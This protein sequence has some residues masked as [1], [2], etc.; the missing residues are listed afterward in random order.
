MALLVLIGAV[1][2][3]AATRLLWSPSSGPAAAGA[4]AAPGTS[5]GGGNAGATGPADAAAIAATVND[6]IVD[7]TTSS[8]YDRSEAAGTGMVLTSDGEVLTNNHVIAGATTISVTDVGNGRTYDA[9]VVGYDRSHDVAVLQ[10]TDASGLATV[11]LGDSSAV[12][13]GQSVVGVGNAGGR[14]GTPSFA[15]GTVTAL[16]RSITASDPATGAG[17]ELDGL[18]ET[19][20]AIVAGDSGGPLVDTDGAVIGIDSAASAGLRSRVPGGPAYAVPIN[21]A[22]RIVHQIESGTPTADVHIGPTAF[23]GVGLRSSAGGAFVARVVPGGPAEA[24]GLEVGDTITAL[25]GHAVDD[26][27]SLTDLMLAEQPG[28]DV[29]VRYRDRSGADGTATVRLGSGPAQ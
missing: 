18:I 20:A 23:L 13:V 19:D 27:R 28:A 25:D 9:T 26:A 7:I 2:G 15:G 1:G 10:L 6:G 5:P 8:S 22:M 14:G 17:E 21:D 11:T 4:G 12:R 29:E 3:A 24:A 16:D